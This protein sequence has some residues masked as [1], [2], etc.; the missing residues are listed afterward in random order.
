MTISVSL[1]DIANV[2]GATL[3]GNGDRLLTGLASLESA[4]A[5]DLSFLSSK[6]FERHLSSTKAGAV[7]LR[8]DIAE[9]Y[10]G[11]ALIADDP[12]LAFAKASR[13]FDTRRIGA[14][15]IHP[16]AIVAESAQ[17][18]TN[19]SIAAH[20]TI[21]E[22]VRIGDDSE[23]QPGV[24]IGDDCQIGDNARIYANVTLYANV[25]MGSHVTVHSATVIGS[26][27]FG[28]A[29]SSD[30]WV[31]IYQLGG[32]LIGDNVDIGSGTTIDRGAI[33]DTIIS[34]G[35]IIDNQVHIAHNIE[36]GENTA[37]AGCVGIAGS[38]KIGKNCTFGGACGV[39]GHISIPDNVHF[40]G[41]T[42]VSKGPKEPGV[43]SSASPMM[44][45]KKW[46]RT[47]VR[48]SQ[49]EDIVERLSKLE[50]A[51]K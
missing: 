10:D 16:S 4:G 33:G 29:P 36:I 20:C 7:I 25:R 35:V 34:D 18:G 44:E 47:A 2:S 3:R 28:F 1:A 49:L 48:Y 42:I 27:G 21:G 43:Y 23:I 38:T 22:N 30:G 9:L 31:K 13:L 15:G 26:D 14:P 6:P 19:V 12:Y 50:K 46:R 51:N 37:I 5:R 41:G 45:V 8:E 40:Q 32:V 39:T 11:N 17:I 24:V